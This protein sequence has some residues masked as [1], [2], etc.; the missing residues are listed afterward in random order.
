MTPHGSFTDPYLRAAMKRLGQVSP[1]GVISMTDDST[2]H[3]DA[4]IELAAAMS[5]GS[6]AR[7]YLAL[8]RRFVEKL[9][10]TQ[11]RRETLRGLV[12]PELGAA[13]FDALM[14]EAEARERACSLARAP[15]APASPAT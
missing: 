6:Q 3:P 12:A 2:F 9:E 1:Q 14:D 4:P 5:Q 13:E 7:G 11:Y 8:L 10:P 15:S